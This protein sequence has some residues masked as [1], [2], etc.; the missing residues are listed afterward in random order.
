MIKLFAS[1]MSPFHQHFQTIPQIIL[2]L[3]RNQYQKER[4]L[5]LF[6]RD[7]ARHCFLDYPHSSMILD[8]TQP[9]QKPSPYNNILNFSFLPRDI[10]SLF[11]PF[12]SIVQNKSFLE[13]SNNLK[14]L[15][16]PFCH[17]KTIQY[18]FNMHNQSR[19]SPFHLIQ[20]T[21]KYHHKQF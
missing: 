9:T 14:T 18:I 13:Q 11:I 19:F 4:N 10:S 7:I 1:L 20:I 12:S 6:Y 21:F 3:I 15:R 16:T 2:E 8:S 17:S 5:M